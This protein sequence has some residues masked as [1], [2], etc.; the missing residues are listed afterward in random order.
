[1]LWQNSIC[2]LCSGPN[3][4]LN[5]LRKTAADYELSCYLWLKIT[6]MPRAQ[7]GRKAYYTERIDWEEYKERRQRSELTGY[8]CEEEPLSLRKV[9]RNPNFRL[10]FIQAK[11]AFIVGDVV[12]LTICG[13]AIP[14]GTSSI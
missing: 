12:Y 3:L 13:P 4:R 11:A 6:M 5:L 9:V 1:M 10:L 2:F 7:S 8:G 14:A